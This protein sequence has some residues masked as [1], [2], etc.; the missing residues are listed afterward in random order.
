VLVAF[1]PPARL[2]EYHESN[3]RPVADLET[4]GDVDDLFYVSAPHRVYLICGSG[5]IDVRDAASDKYSRL[6]QIQTVAAARTGLFA[7][8]CNA[9]Y[10]GVRGHSREPPFWIYALSRQHLARA[11]GT[12]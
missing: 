8:E 6:T 9:L 12:K 1:R 5:A 3:A 10:V 11:L 7:P 2:V 4:C